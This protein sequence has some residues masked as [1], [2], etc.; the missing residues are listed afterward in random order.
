MPLLS[1]KV[2]LCGIC[3]EP[4]EPSRWVAPLD[5]GVALVN[6]GSGAGMSD[7]A[8]TMSSEQ[9]TYMDIYNT[10][11][12]GFG[13]RIWGKNMMVKNIDQKRMVQKCPYGFP[14][15]YICH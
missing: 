10:L 4:E 15:R 8:P 11:Y 1:Y 13:G 6:P 14:D 3:V 7:L 12:S 2:D 5:K 9:K